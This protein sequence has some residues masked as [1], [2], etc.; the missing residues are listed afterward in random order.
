MRASGPTE[1]LTSGRQAS[2]HFSDEE[3]CY[4]GC[5]AHAAAPTLHFALSALLNLSSVC[6]H[7]ALKLSEERDITSQF[8]PRPPSCSVL[9]II[10]FFYSPVLWFYKWNFSECDVSP[11]DMT[12]FTSFDLNYSWQHM[13]IFCMN[14]QVC[15]RALL[16]PTDGSGQLGSM[17]LQIWS[18]WAQ[19]EWFTRL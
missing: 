3:L 18:V 5:I 4:L 16:P 6:K 9:K 17:T 13:Q 10:V 15:I 7:R 8:T 12:G 1:P 14:L 19:F 2:V 11:T